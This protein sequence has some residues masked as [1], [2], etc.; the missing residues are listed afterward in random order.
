M[1]VLFESVARAA[2]ARTFAESEESCVVFGMP[3]EAIRMEAADAVPAI[4][5]MAAALLGA[6]A[7]DRKQAS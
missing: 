4:H 6:V 5:D 3:R 7:T 2:G 1:D